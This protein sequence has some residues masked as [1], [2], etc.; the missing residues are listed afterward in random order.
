[1]LIMSVFSDHYCIVQL[2][3]SNFILKLWIYLLNLNFLFIYFLKVRLLLPDVSV[4]TDDF[5]FASHNSRPYA[6]ARDCVSNSC[7]VQERKGRFNVDLT[8][9]SFHLPDVIPYDFYSFPTC[10]RKVYAASMSED[11][12]RWSG[13]CG[14][15]CGSCWPKKLYLLV[16]GC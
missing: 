15:S 10:V 5:T 4:K 3:Y 12:L 11:Q 6:T 2:N 13:K 16:N 14:G 9:T 1:M 7:K 8:G